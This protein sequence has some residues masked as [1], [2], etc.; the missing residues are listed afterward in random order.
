V[1]LPQKI[2]RKELA[3]LIGVTP[4][5][6]DQLAEDGHIPK[7]DGGMI[8]FKGAIQGLLNRKKENTTPAVERLNLAKAKREERKDRIEEGE[9]M[10]SQDVYRV[11]ENIVLAVRE[12][13][14]KIG[15]NVQSK[16]GATEEQRKTIE[17]EASDA[18]KELEKQL[19]YMAELEESE[20][21]KPQPNS[22]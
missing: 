21:D 12:R 2:H 17:Q 11:W 6:I 9:T 19:I 14:L 22:K 18:L 20:D 7:L 16:C 5:R 13:V 15:N 1:T 8:D 10:Q 4:R 3:E